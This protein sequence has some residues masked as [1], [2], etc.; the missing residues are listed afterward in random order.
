VDVKNRK[1]DA[2][3]ANLEG[4]L[5]ELS[6]A[7]G[8]DV[9]ALRTRVE[10]SIRAAKSALGKQGTSVTAR[11]GRYAGSVDKYITSFPRLGFLTGVLVGGALIYM[12]GRV[13]P[14][15]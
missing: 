3:V 10:E 8:P 13:S 14:R 4:L 9:Q 5:D 15:D 6:E 11:V 7:H 1:F 12:A 2:L